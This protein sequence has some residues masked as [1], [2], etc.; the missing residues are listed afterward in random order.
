MEFNLEKDI[1]FFDIESTGLS[2]A[3]DRIVQL[4]IIKYFAD[5]SEPIERSRLINP[6]IPIN[7]E[8]TDVHGITNEQVKDE[9][10]FKDLANGLMQLIGD[11]DLCGFNSNRF[12][13]PMLIEE[14]SRAG[15]ELSTDDRNFID[16]WKVYQKMEPR[17]LSA[18]CKYY[19]GK[20]L[21]GAHDALNDV[22]ATVDVLR[23][24][25]KMYEGVNYD[26]GKGEIEENPIRNNMKALHDFTNFKNKIDFEGKFLMNED[27]V[28]IF[29]FG[30]FQDK[31][32]KDVV[33]NNPWYQKWFLDQEFSSDTKKVFRKLIEESE[34]ETAQKVQ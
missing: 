28:A 3:N 34:Q 23:G 10:T 17:N 19:C 4:A 31:S 8:A 5:G 21:E 24:Q 22:R 32:V 11:A 30:K 6:T 33:K 18:A 27:G 16:V 12:D 20:E 9:P 2:T 26:D 14:F 29:N 15:I 7:P 13:V 1:V 25:L